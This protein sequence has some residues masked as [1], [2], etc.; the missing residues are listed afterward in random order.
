MIE[1]IRGADYVLTAAAA[2]TAMEM[3]GPEVTAALVAELPK[4]PA[5]KQ[6]LL[7]NTLGYRGDASAGPALLALASKGPR[8]SVWPPSR[9]S[10]TWATRRPCRC[11][12]SCRSRA[13]PIWPRPRKPAWAASPA[14]TPMPRSWPCSPTRTPRSA[15]WPSR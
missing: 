11:W 12:P 14:R 3:P 15:A 4:L 5:D 13:R 6:M 2:R 7:V 9:I 8:P 10:R 1:A